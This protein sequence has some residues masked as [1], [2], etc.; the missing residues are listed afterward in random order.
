M[1]HDKLYLLLSRVSS[2]LD[3][4]DSLSFAPDLPRLAA[5]LERLPGKQPHCEPVAESAR[6]IKCDHPSLSPESNPAKRDTD[7]FC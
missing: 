1:R 4:R 3:T 7:E 5:G 6:R 2:P